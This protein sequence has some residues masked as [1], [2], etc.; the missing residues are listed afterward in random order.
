MITNCVEKNI[1]K[2][3]KLVTK[4]G[5]IFHFNLCISYLYTQC[6]YYGYIKYN[7]LKYD[8]IFFFIN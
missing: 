1:E 4:L 7:E 5:F 6:I 3:T 8:Y 2:V